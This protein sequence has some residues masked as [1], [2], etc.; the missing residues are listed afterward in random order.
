MRKGSTVYVITDRIIVN[1][2]RAQ[3][4][5]K[6]H[7]VIAL[8][9]AIAPG[10]P[11]VAAIAILLGIAIIIGVL[12]L[13]R[14]AFRRKW[15]TI[16]EVEIGQRRFEARRGQGLNIELKKPRRLAYGYVMVAS[17]MGESIDLR[18]SGRKNFKIARNLLVAF[19]PARV[20]DS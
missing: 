5:W 6:T 8:L 15:P 11:A 12:L 18:I 10:V 7:I 13:R 14:R 20:K 9:V 19:E 16:I 4:N 1:K 17:L 2:G 3:L